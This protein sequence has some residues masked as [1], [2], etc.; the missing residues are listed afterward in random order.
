MIRPASGLRPLLIRSGREGPSHRACRGTRK[1]GRDLMLAQ[2]RAADPLAS[3]APL[4]VAAEASKIWVAANF[5][6]TTGYVTRYSG[7]LEAIM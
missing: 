5:I 6:L 2:T 4:T 7:A 3:A 1:L